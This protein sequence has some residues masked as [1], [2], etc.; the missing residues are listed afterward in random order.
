VVGP[1]PAREAL[2]RETQP[3]RYVLV[4]ADDG[5]MRARFWSLLLAGAVAVSLWLLLKTTT[6]CALSETNCWRP[7]AA[8]PM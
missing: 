5:T 3:S 1:V 4:V 6:D 8:W 7:S 2:G